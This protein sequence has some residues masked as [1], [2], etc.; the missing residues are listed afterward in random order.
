MRKDWKKQIQDEQKFNPIPIDSKPTGK[1]YYLWKNLGPIKKLF[2]TP[3][4]LTVILIWII[5][6]KDF[7]FVEIEGK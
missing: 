6:G 7:A 2:S 3:I 5:L 4:Y 1:V